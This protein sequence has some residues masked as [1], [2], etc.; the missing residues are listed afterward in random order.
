MKRMIQAALSAVMM[1]SLAAC[2]S[3]GQTATTTA[4]TETTQTETTAV[5]E[6]KEESPEE[7]LKIVE[8]SFSDQDFIFGGGSSGGTYNAVASV[9]AQFFTKAGV[10]HYTAQA[11]TGS[12]Q[13]IAFIKSGDIEFAMANSGTCLD[14][15][16]GVGS[17]EGNA[18]E[19][20]RAICMVY[21][22]IFQEFVSTSSGIESEQDL[23][24]KKLAIGGPGSGDV[25]ECTE[26]YDVF[27]M[28]IDDYEPQYLGTG[29]AADSMK[30]GHIDGMAFIGQYPASA[31]IELTSKAINKAKLIGLS[32]ETIQKLA[33]A[34]DAKYFEA[35]V[36][37]GTYGNQTE[38]I[39]TIAN[40]QLMVTSADADEEL[41]Y[42][43]TK[44]IYENLGELSIYHD[45]LSDMSLDSALLTTG[46]PMHPGA[47]RYYREVGLIK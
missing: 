17:F 22:G 12:G 5:A 32:E 29:E 25:V 4:A 3:S 13:N 45:A 34:E 19:D 44:T 46:V 39:Y 9:F 40:G 10:A 8:S 26:V 43:M 24:G 16:N 6:Q 47:E 2:S 37:A 31:L 41:V 28:S 14:A 35:V 11:T 15:M 7:G 36:P 23:F 38:D 30:D 27:G 1:I 42:L 20:L 18:Y 21:P 33:G